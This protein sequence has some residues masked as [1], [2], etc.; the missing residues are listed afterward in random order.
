LTG[1]SSP[2]VFPA[3]HFYSKFIANW[4]P[5]VHHSAKTAY[6]GALGRFGRSADLPIMK[7]N[8]EIVMEPVT[9][10]A[11][12]FYRWAAEAGGEIDRQTIL[13]MIM[14]DCKHSKFV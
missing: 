7:Q 4:V 8:T 1:R 9:Q 5:T 6:S 13:S 3:F 2:I 14:N 11:G 12:Y 10:L